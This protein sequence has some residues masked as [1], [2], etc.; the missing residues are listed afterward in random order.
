VPAVKRL[1]Y[2]SRMPANSPL[3]SG[4]TLVELL[5]TVAVLAVIL[6]LAVPGF[7]SFMQNDQQWVQQNSLVM[8][9]NAARSE[10]IKQDVGGGVSVCASLDGLTCGPAGTAWSQGWIVLSPANPKPVM[11]VGALPT[12]TTLS[13]AGGASA[14]TFL[15]SGMVTAPVAFTMCDNR[16]A[17]QA[18]YTQVTFTGRV[19]SANQLGMNLAG[20]ALACP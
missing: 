7:R 12:G 1:P 2:Y 4:F 5:V 10:A 9:L 15:S 20:A 13:E 16:G 19:L 6:A 8:S 14:V 18:R 11:S 17:A 3:Q